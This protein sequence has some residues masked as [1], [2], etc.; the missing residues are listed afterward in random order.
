MTPLPRELQRDVDELRAAFGQVETDVGPEGLVLLFVQ[1]RSVE[2]QVI[3]DLAS[4]PERPPALY[5]HRGWT[6][7]LVSAGGRVQGLQSLK[8]W[9]R[10]L[11][12]VHVVRE[13]HHALVVSPPRAK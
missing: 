1:V 9:N 4:Y 2:V 12:V 3:I 11:G 7:S 5:I 13:L 10:T 6:H 8:E